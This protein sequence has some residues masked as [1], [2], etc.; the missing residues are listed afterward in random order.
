VSGLARG[1]FAL[2][3]DS[4]RTHLV[5]GGIY[6]S[7]SLAAAIVAIAAILVVTAVVA[8]LIEI[9]RTVL[10]A[11]TLGVSLIILTAIALTL[12]SLIAA[13]TVLLVSALLAGALLAAA[14]LAVLMR[15]VFRLCLLAA[16]ENA[17]KFL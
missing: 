7:G 17:D 8:G 11:L 4:A 10:A 15:V 14:R 13:L 5:G 6:R 16:R 9:L 12:L 3:N 2:G 1:H